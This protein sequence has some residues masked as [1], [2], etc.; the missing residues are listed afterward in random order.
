MNCAPSSNIMVMSSGRLYVQLT[1]VAQGTASSCQPPELFSWCKYS[2]ELCRRAFR[3]VFGNGWIDSQLREVLDLTT[4]SSDRR[5]GARHLRIL[6]GLSYSPDLLLSHNHIL[7]MVKEICF[8][9]FV[10]G[11][12]PRMTRP[13]GTIVGWAQEFC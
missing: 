2:P 6:K 5:E 4:Y 10:I 11:M 1:P 12:F 9:D 13:R 8:Q 7:P 3:K